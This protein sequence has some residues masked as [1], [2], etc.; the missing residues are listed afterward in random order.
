MTT[1]TDT[2]A[3]SAAPE[4]SD[5]APD[6]QEAVLALLTDLSSTVNDLKGRVEAVEQRPAKANFVPA[7]PEQ[8]SAP[9]DRFER[10]QVAK[11]AEPDGIPRTRTV[12]VFSDGQRVPDY[13]LSRLSA[14]FGPGS[15]VRFN[16]DAVPHGVPNGKTRGECF[17]EIDP[18][19]D[20]PKVRYPDVVGEVFDRKFLSKDGIWKYRVRFPEGVIPGATKGF[21]FIYETELM[22][23]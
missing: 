3:A 22:A 20:Q 15:R 14:Q 16:L 2:G 19:T 5:T 11:G 9:R 23:A 4:P 21:L 6:F 12:P 7:T 13:V 18:E 1:T 10:G 8:F 17:A